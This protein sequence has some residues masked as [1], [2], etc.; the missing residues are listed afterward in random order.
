MKN[1]VPIWYQHKI[2]NDLDGSI[3]VN[4]SIL[5]FITNFIPR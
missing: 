4:L 1:Q 3:M 2:Q 5:F